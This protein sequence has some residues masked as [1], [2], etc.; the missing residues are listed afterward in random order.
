MDLESVH[1]A[2]L[3]EPNPLTWGFLKQQLSG[4]LQDSFQR[5]ATCIILFDLNRLSW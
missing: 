3:G 5:T 4:K 2:R 1:G